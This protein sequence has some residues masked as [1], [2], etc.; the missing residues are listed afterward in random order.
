ML[1]PKV[2]AL[3]DVEEFERCEVEPTNNGY[4]ALVDRYHGLGHVLVLCMD[5]S[6]DRYFLWILGGSCGQEYEY[7][8]QE[9]MRLTPGRIKWQTEDEAIEEFKNYIV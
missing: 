4:I 3:L 7:N 9:F 5:P 2:K 8:L 6:T 1:S